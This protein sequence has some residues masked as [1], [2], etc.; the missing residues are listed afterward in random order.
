M[1]INE[2]DRALIINALRRAANSYRSASRSQLL[3][4]VECGLARKWKRDAERLD[5]LAQ[6]F[7]GNTNNNG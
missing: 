1:T 2:W 7:E 4:T 5:Q 3:P 6:S